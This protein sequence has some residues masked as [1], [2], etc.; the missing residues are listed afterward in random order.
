MNDM[1]LKMA[2][3][4]DY[5]EYKTILLKWFSEHWGKFHPNR[6][7]KDWES[8]LHFNKDKLP[9][10]IIV[11]DVTAHGL[12]LVG[13]A[14]LRVG[15]HTEI[16]SFATENTVWLERVY[17]HPDNRHKNIASMLLKECIKLVKTLQV[18]KQP[19]KELVL[20][21]RHA[22]ELYKKHGWKEIGK[23]AY[24]GAPVALMVR[25]ITPNAENTHNKIKYSS[26]MWQERS[27]K[28][29]EEQSFRI[30][31]TAERSSIPCSHL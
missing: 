20:L 21:T 19:I 27:N 17:I 16:G 25:A 12:T 5:P 14:A 22:D 13:T 23:P 2:Y 1:T 28:K 8:E 26:S 31:Q 30:P 29:N 18:D 24:Q 6:N 4:A 10:T 11:F 9:V 7:L 15:I 3:L